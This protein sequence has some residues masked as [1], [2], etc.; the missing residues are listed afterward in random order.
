V[1]RGYIADPA[2]E[3]G[4]AKWQY[5]FINGRWIRDRSLSHALQEAYRG[6]IMTG[7]FPVA[8]LFLELPPDQV[9]VNVHPTK[10]EVKFR[11]G[12]ALHHLVYAAVR[13]RLH[14]SNLTPRLQPPPT[15]AETPQ[16]VPPLPR[17][18]E[19]SAGEPAAADLWEP[20]ASS[21]TAPSPG[22]LS[23]VPAGPIGTPASPSRLPA[24]GSFKAIQLYD[25]YLV[26]ETDEGML[27]IDQHALH[28]RILFEQFKERMAQGPLEAQR[29]LI[30]VPI[31]M[32]VEQAAR[33]LEHQEALAAL[34]LGV[35]D[36]GG[37]TLLLTSYPALLGNR[38]PQSIFKR[39]VDH[40]VSKERPPSREH[41][42]NE[43]LSLMACHAA[44]RAGD[45]LSSEEMEA[46]VAQR[47]LARDAHHC[48]HG[49][50]T[51]L[52]FSRQEL[53]RQFRR[54]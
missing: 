53:E 43:M 49:R 37:G 52:L 33:T 28:E 8:F 14:A 32:T 4:T 1:L 39:V 5:L 18:Q 38:S 35:E 30:P 20:P 6:L 27:V 45:R 24:P 10:A 42:L 7:R 17:L 47:N 40:L 23:P 48:P 3:R 25:M 16:V 51:S 50:P 31:D 22:I 21:P 12:Q 54:V 13:E 46:L 29:L 11:D 2:C 26:L 19:Q 9:D 41:L 36:F 44:V 34:G 15:T